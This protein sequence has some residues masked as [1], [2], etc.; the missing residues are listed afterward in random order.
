MPT[1][2]RSRACRQQR[3][4]EGDARNTAWRALGPVE[5]LRQLD[6]RLGAGT[7]ARRQ[8]AMLTMLLSKG[9]A[10]RAHAR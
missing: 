7:G 10:T 8:R 2:T 1:Q 5:Q 4:D 9:P 6:A 3:R